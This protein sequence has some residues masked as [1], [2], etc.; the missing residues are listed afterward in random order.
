MSLARRLVRFTVLLHMV[1]YAFEPIFNTFHFAFRHFR[2]F[3]SCSRQ[4]PPQPFGRRIRKPPRMWLLCIAPFFDS[5]L[6]SSVCPRQSSIVYLFRERDRPP[7]AF[8][9]LTDLL[10]RANYTHILYIIKPRLVSFL[11][12][13]FDDTEPFPCFHCTFFYSMQFFWS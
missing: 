2:F 9:F 6:C 11:V 3:R 1:C 13:I 5:S 7:P 12:A 10:Y 8:F 4:S